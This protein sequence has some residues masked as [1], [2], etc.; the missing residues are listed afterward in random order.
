MQYKFYS[1][2]HGIFTKIDH[3]LGHNQSHQI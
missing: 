1:A 3:I 2:G